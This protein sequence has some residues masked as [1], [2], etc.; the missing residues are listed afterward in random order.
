MKTFH[1]KINSI[2]KKIEGFPLLIIRL[3]LAYGLYTPAMNKWADI[4]AIADWFLGLG[5]PAPLFQAYLAAG[6]EISG[7]VLLTLGLGTRF[8]SL[9]LMITMLVAIKTVHWENGFDAS[10][11][12]F[13]IPLYYLIL[14][15]TL[16]VYGSGKLSLDYLISKRRAKKESLP[17][18]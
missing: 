6:T 12:G 5:L 18:S 2:L 15:F 13:E 17:I 10:N 4:H 3:I 8:I 9:P 16:L 7:V 14:L 1:L 11:N